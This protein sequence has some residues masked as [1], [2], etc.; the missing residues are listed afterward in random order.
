ML[1]AIH[2]LVRVEREDLRRGIANFG[3]NREHHAPHFILAAQ[4]FVVGFIDCLGCEHRSPALRPPIA[5][6]RS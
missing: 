1:A 2:R 4:W 6:L 5:A 3:F